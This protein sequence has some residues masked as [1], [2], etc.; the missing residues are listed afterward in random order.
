VLAEGVPVTSG[1]G[2]VTITDDSDVSL[3]AEVDETD[4][5]LVRRGVGAD[6]ELD[7]VPGATYQ[8]VVTSVEA[9]PAS[10][11]SGSVSYR[12]RLRLGPGADADGRSA[13]APRV[14]MS[15]VVDLRVRTAKDAVSVPVSAVFRVG[16]RDA[17]WVVESGR[18][19]QRLV[20]LGAQGEDA[21]QVASGLQTGERV[22]VSGA[23][24]LHEGQAVG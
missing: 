23:D 7:A 20:A 1:G 13:P 6:V 12:V 4:V 18:A 5:L 9:N 22:V 16:A 19:H 10:S 11:S 17:V 2:L 24:R 15:A 21:V 14:G 8:A 3:S